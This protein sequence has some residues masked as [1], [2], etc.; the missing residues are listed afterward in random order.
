MIKVLHPGFYSTI[1]D[2]GRRDYQHLGVP[3][4]GAMDQHA[5]KSANAILGNDENCAVLEI[6][7]LGPNL[8]FCCDTVITISGADLQPKLNGIKIRLFSATNVKTGD[9]LSFGR[10]IK[11]FR[12]YLAVSKGFQTED[13]LNSKSMYKGLTAASRLQKGDLIKLIPTNHINNKYAYVKFDGNI[14]V[15][16]IVV[17]KGP[18]FE[19]LNDKQINQLFGQEFTISKENNRMAYQLDELITNSLYEIITSLVMPGTIQLTPLGKLIILMR[20]CQTTGGYPRILQ[21]SEYSISVLA[22]K[23]VGD[24]IIFKL[25]EYQL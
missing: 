24:K 13:I 5:L 7:M 9:V 23:K 20:D 22:Q 16:I 19:H 21:L 3:L 18:E 2:L 10:L 4:S 12:A 11:G 6:T 17:N 1:Q 14:D 8:E 25:E 15:D